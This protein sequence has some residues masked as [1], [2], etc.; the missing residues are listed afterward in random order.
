MAFHNP[1][2]LNLICIYR[3][4]EIWPIKVAI[5]YHGTNTFY[6]RTMIDEDLQ[7]FIPNKKM[8]GE[9]IK[10]LVEMYSLRTRKNRE[11]WLIDIGYWT[12]MMNMTVDDT[13]SFYDIIRNDLRDLQPDLDDDLYFFEGKTIVEYYDMFLSI[14]FI[15]RKGEICTYLGTLWYKQISSE[16]DIVLGIME[17]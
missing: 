12:A 2:F 16:K 15:C 6:N 14:S 13:T 7:V 5:N 3:C 1:R 10:Q 4:K 17:P 9:S 8:I 11:Y